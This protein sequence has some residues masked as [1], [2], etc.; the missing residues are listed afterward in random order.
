M[1]V[2][3]DRNPVLLVEDDPF[4]HAKLSKALSHHNISIDWAENAEECM[5]FL[6]ERTYA[7]VI[8][9]LDLSGKSKDTK[10]IEWKDTKGIKLTTDLTAHQFIDEE[11]YTV[12]VV[13][14][15]YRDEK[16][17]RKSRMSGPVV[18]KNKPRTKEECKSFERDFPI[19][20]ASIIYM[21]EH[22]AEMGKRQANDMQQ[23]NARIT[24]DEVN[25]SILT[26]ADKE[27]RLRAKQMEILTILMQ[28]EVPI[29]AMVLQ[30]EARIKSAKSLKET[31]RTLNEELEKN[32]ATIRVVSEYRG[33]FLETH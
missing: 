20:L 3:Y 29:P 16:I 8:M 2:S 24:W 1:A 17:I 10:G 26:V 5:A 27:I 32:C 33:Y 7:V 19:S 18:V 4:W 25:R 15:D 22:H 12:V 11:R 13:L 21:V 23:G 9:D 31:C 30:K 6:S 14:T 28:S